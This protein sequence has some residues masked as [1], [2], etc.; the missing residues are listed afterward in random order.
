MK[1]VWKNK[2]KIISGIWNSWFPTKF[3]KKVSEERFKICQSNKCGQYDG[4]GVS[5][6]CYVPGHPCCNACGCKLSW[7]VFSLSKTCGLEELGQEPLWK[8]VMTEKEEEI[9]R[10]KSGIKN[11]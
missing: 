1:T 9:F 8:A 10:K 4:H 11:D 2:W 5:Y 7:A 6:K 3:I